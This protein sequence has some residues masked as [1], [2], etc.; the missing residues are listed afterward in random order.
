MKTQQFKLDKCQFM[1]DLHGDKTRTAKYLVPTL[2]AFALEYAELI[3]PPDLDGVQPTR[4]FIGRGFEISN[5][6]VLWHS[7]R[8][9]LFDAP[10]PIL[11]VHYHGI[12]DYQLLFPAVSSSDRI[13][14]LAYYYEEAE[15]C[16]EAGAWLSFMLMCGAVFEGLLSDRVGSSDNKKFN[17]L[18]TRASEQELISGAEQQLIDTVREYRNMVHLD[19]RESRYVS[20][21]DVMD[22][23]KALDVIVHRFSYGPEEAEA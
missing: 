23:R 18:I 1:P 2:P 8:Q 19:N 4:L 22:T 15:K 6:T 20:R 14:R 5:D 17:L 13:Q 21:A 12:R 10:E 9:T 3:V 7:Y 11:I 16:F